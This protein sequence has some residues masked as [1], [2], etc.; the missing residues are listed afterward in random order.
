MSSMIEGPG[1]PFNTVLL[2]R[3]L[4]PG[5]YTSLAFGKRC[6]EAGILQSMG[7]VGDA[8]DNA[9]SSDNQDENERLRRHARERMTGF[10]EG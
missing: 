10:A 1:K 8:Y 7:S 4:E 3:L 5:Q 6:R 9:L 2:R